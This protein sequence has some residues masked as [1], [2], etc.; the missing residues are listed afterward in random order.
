VWTKHSRASIACLA[1][2]VAVIGSAA[3]VR[4]QPVVEG[5]KQ[6]I[7]AAEET[8][9]RETYLPE[10]CE[11]LKD[12]K[13]FLHRGLREKKVDPPIV[14]LDRFQQQLA[15]RVAQA[16]MT[17]AKAD[18]LLAQAKRRI[19]ELVNACNLDYWKAELAKAQQQSQIKGGTDPKAQFN[20][21]RTYGG[22][23][24][25]VD[26]GTLTGSFE[27]WTF[28]GRG[29]NGENVTCSGQLDPGTTLTKRGDARGRMKC[30]AKWGTPQNVWICDGIGFAANSSTAYAGGW[31]WFGNPGIGDVACRGTIAEGG[32]PAAP[33]QFGQI[34]FFSQLG[35]PLQD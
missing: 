18:E 12:G 11:R 5:L 15:K 23:V 16:R 20:W 17:Q 4:A 26:A 6:N 19:S 1:S 33:Q 14:S 13:S 34:Y 2:V 8:L 31:A 7:K 30:E 27:K 28:T 32:K 29:P 22:Y 9:R 10:Y 35:W 3:A 25:R 24:L 21:N